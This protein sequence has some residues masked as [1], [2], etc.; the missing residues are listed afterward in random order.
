LDSTSRNTQQ[1]INT[2]KETIV[3]SKS[4]ANKSYA[5]II[6]VIL[7]RFQKEKANLVIMFKGPSFILNGSDYLPWLSN[8]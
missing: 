3:F 6:V 8:F 5:T 7:S 2:F 4:K 1:H